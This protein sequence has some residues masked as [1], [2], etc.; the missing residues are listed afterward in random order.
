[1]DGITINGVAP[2]W[3]HTGSSLPEEL[4]SASYTSAGSRGQARRKWRQRVAFLASKE[5][6]YITGQ[7]L[8]VERRKYSSGNKNGRLCS[9][10]LQGVRLPAA[11]AQTLRHARKAFSN[12]GKQLRRRRENPSGLKA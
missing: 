4:Q 11:R 2:G 3:V 12:A 5:A 9:S 7:V 6:S 10:P 1:M 8:V